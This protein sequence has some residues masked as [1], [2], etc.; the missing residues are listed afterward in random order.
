MYLLKSKDEVFRKFAEFQTRV[1]KQLGYPITKLKNDRG[2]EYQSK[3]AEAYLKEHD[4]IAETA[5]SYSPQSN[6]IAKRKN[7]TLTKMINSMPITSGLPTCFW[8]E[9]LLMALDLEF[10]TLL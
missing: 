1:E 10:G 9:M 7:H 3:E 6:E 4:I 5:A 2:G 8:G